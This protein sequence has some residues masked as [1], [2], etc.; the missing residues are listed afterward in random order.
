MFDAG[1]GADRPAPHGALA[2]VPS[3]RPRVTPI[4]ADDWNLLFDAVVE[5]LAQCVA[6]ADVSPRPAHEVMCECVQAL[7]KL[8]GVTAPERRTSRLH[9]S[10][11]AAPTKPFSPPL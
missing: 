2:A 3:P 4:A 10:D 1:S 6:A 7:Q 11:E 5:R 8:R 9:A